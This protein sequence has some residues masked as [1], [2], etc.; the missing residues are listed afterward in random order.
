MFN[1]TTTK[2]LAEYG[3]IPISSCFV[4]RTPIK[5]VFHET[6][7]VISGGKYNKIRKELPE[8]YHVAMVCGLMKGDEAHN[9]LIEKNE[10]INVAPFR[11]SDIEKNT[12]TMRIQLRGITINRMLENAKT[13][14][15]S[16]K[17]FSYNAI[18][19]GN[20]QRNN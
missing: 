3:D 17:F 20:E 14:M 18:G 19:H 12:E 8:L 9:I 5:K 11:Q 2:T 10:T 1:N 13:A 16:E 15:G 7:N 6:I 4:M